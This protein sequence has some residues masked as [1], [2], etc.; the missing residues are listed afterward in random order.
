MVKTRINKLALELNVQNDQIIDE[1]KKKAIPVKNYMSSIDE[2][3]TTY[4]RE[5]FSKDDKKADKKKVGVKA[6]KAHKPTKAKAVQKK[7]PTAKTKAAVTTKV[8][9]KPTAVKKPQ[10]IA[11]TATK[12]APKKPIKPVAKA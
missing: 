2:E 5:F 6:K 9:K 12:P 10:A 7:K 11:K 4:I 3:A 8:A 1:L